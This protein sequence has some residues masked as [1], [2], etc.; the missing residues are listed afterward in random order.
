MSYRPVI[1]IYY[2]GRIMDCIYCRNFSEKG[3]VLT[4][5]FYAGYLESCRTEKEVKR[6]LFGKWR[7][8]PDAAYDEASKEIEEWSDRTIQVDLT[9]RCIF[10]GAGPRTREKLAER[11]EPDLSRARRLFSDKAPLLTGE[12]KISFESMDLK[13]VRRQPFFYAM[14]K[15]QWRRIGEEAA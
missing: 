1:S 6:R 12:T 3:L 4:A 15:D 2:E 9:S 7:N 10:A 13:A 14:L 5:L 8:W 11:K